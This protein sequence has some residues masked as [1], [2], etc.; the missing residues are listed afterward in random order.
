MRPL[1]R[2]IMLAV[3]VG[4]FTA[5]C[6]GSSPEDASSSVRASRPMIWPSAEPGPY[7]V[8]YRVMHEYDATRTFRPKRD[9][10]GKPAEGTIARPIQISVWYPAVLEAGQ[11]RMKLEDYYL[12]KATETDFSPPSPERLT[13]LMNRLK[14]I[15]PIEFRV[16]PEGREAIRGK[17]DQALREEVFAVKDAVPEK[18]PFPLIV[19]MPG[20]N[21]SPAHHA[22]L[23]EYL[24]SRGYVVAAVPNMDF[25]NETKNLG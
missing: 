4:T 24:A 6:P 11:G 21:A 16:P 7:D 15:W 1:L 12:A 20:Y 18:G 8:G 13:I 25:M 14:S 5:A 23:F 2:M 17:I 19:H 9:Y 3:A 22:Y 10:F